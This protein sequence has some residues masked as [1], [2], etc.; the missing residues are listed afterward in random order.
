VSKNTPDD[1]TD[2]GRQRAIGEVVSDAADKIADLASAPFPV[3]GHQV[4]TSDSNERMYEVA[5]KVVGRSRP[6]EWVAC[7]KEGPAARLSRRMDA[8][9]QRMDR[10]SNN[11]EDDR[12]SD[13]IEMARINKAIDKFIGEREFKHWL[14]PIITAI[15]GSSVA[16]IIVSYLI[17]IQHP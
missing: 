11:Y 3:R 16:A 7:E 17:R 10:M 15:A 4:R 5:E 14:F 12:K 8:A 9:E 6:A 1:L 2:T 13:A